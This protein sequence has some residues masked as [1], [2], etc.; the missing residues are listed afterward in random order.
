M[1]AL[2]I[3][4]PV[5]MREK[6]WEPRNCSF[7]PGLEVSF[8]VT[9]DLENLGC[10]RP[11]CVQMWSPQAQTCQGL[12]V[13]GSPPCLLQPAPR[14]ALGREESESFVSKL[15]LQEEMGVCCA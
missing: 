3:A 9:Y 14:V 10:P 11:S 4:G 13:Q 7:V 6:G 1:V 5:P 2:R 15:G 8:S 12:F